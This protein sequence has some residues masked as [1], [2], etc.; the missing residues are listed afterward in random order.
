MGYKGLNRT[1]KAA[2]VD[3][4]SALACQEVFAHGQRQCHILMD[5]RSGRNDILQIHIRRM[6]ALPDQLQEG[7]KVP[8]FQ[9][10]HLSG[11][12]GIFL[13]EM[14]RTEHSTI[15]A[16]LTKFRDCGKEVLL[17]DLGQYL[18]PEI[19]ADRFNLIGNG[20][21]FIGQIRMAGSGVDDAQGMAAG[22]KI[23]VHRSDHWMLPVKEIDGH[24]ITHGRSRLVHQTTGFAEKHIL[25]ILTDPGNLRR[26]YPGIKEQVVEDGADQHFIGGGRTETAA[27]QDGGFT[28]GVKAPDRSS[29]HTAPLVIRMVAADFGTA[30]RGE[31]AVRRA[32]KGCCK[33][34]IQLVFLIGVDLQNRCGHRT[35]L[36]MLQVDPL[37]GQFSSSF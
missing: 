35:Y 9:R 23:K 26:R 18:F 30:R 16:F 31:I 11:N 17:L 10:S 13:I 20:C 2:A 29:Q 7:I 32:A 27:G 1:G 21:I 22:R 24:Q 25:G 8:L 28:I 19:C 36:L 6:A 4:V 5:L 3:A 37:A 33:A 14:D 15:A 12:T 34:C